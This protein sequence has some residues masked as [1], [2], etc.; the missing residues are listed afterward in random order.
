MAP[1][2]GV[3]G[4]VAPPEVLA[5]AREVGHRICDA[6]GTVL[7]GGRHDEGLPAVKVAA[8]EGAIAAARAGRSGARLLGI[9]KED[10]RYPRFAQNA[11]RVGY[12][13][14]GM[15]DARNLLNALTADALVALP[16]KAGTLSEVYYGYAAQ[17]PVVFLGWHASDVERAIDDDMRD[18]QRLE[19]IAAKVQ[20]R[21]PAFAARLAPA[22][23]TMADRLREFIH[24]HYRFAESPAAAADV[25]R[26]AATPRHGVEALE[27]LSDARHRYVRKQLEDVLAFLAG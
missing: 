10:D 4:S 7:T 5:L 11:V 25:L 15:G 9:L 19:R 20:A 13:S 3:F 17:R 18:K 26:E 24:T 27:L 23:G 21:F 1:I 6:G 22:S 12:V 14:T 2:V 16:G 8:L